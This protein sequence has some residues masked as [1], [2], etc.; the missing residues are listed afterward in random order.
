MKI[1][2]AGHTGLV[3]SALVRAIEDS[4]DRNWVGRTRAELDLL[5][6][7][8]VFEFLSKEK[9]DAVIV[10]AAKVGGI[11]A[12]KNFPVDYLSK[13]LQITTNI[14]DGAHE[15]EIPRLLFLASSCVYPKLAPQPINESDLLTG[16]LEDTNEAYAIAKI[17]GLKLVQAYR[18]QFKRDWIAA[19][20][21][22]LYGPGDNYVLEE[23][24]VIP[25]LI[26]RFHEA[27]LSK[28][29]TVKL[30]GTGSPLREF[31]HSNDLA[32]A[33][34]HLLDVYHLEEIINVGSGQEVSILELAEMVSRIVGFEGAIAW[35]PT[36]PDGTP[37]KLLD[38][39]KLK[40]LGW[41]P[42][43]GLVAGLSAAYADFVEN[44]AGAETTK[45]MLNRGT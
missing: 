17:A 35:D 16:P 19:M 15:A 13:N 31:M 36:Y 22:N 34:L 25:A 33:L 18:Q 28:S 45:G 27:K 30:W 9:P 44:H 39:S 4:T 32:D 43:I 10:A 40:N 24:H 6:R 29:E 20:P 2:V 5:D 37:R 3:G 21:T 42:R 8:A 12:N 11:M 38:S 1:Y 14:L 41:S 23:A 7:N 26:R